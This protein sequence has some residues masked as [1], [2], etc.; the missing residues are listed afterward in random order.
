MPVDAETFL[1]HPLSRVVERLALSSTGKAGT[2]IRT[3]V[4]LKV[5][6]R[7]LVPALAVSQSCME[8]RAVDLGVLGVLR[9]GSVLKV[10]QTVVVRVTVQVP[11][12]I[13]LGPGSYERL[14]DQ[15]VDQRS[16]RGSR[17]RHVPVTGYH[18][19]GSK[20]L[21]GDQRQDL[22]LVANQV[23]TL[24]PDYWTPLHQRLNG[25]MALIICSGSRDKSG[26]SPMILSSSRDR[27]GI[28][29]KI[30]SSRS[31][32]S[33]SFSVARSMTWFRN[34]G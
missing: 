2:A 7:E 34:S 5:A 30:L 4:V 31:A 29:A 14:H 27:S 17:D 20:C 16:P 11:D 10:L 25:L 21:T 22:A 19:P 15:R 9:P 33:G 13:S 6:S 23:L 28:F 24:V 1:G 18:R 12:L 8:V 32:R 3:G 26:N